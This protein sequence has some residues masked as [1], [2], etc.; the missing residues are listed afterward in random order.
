MTPDDTSSVPPTPC[1][2]SLGGVWQEAGRQECRAAHQ[3]WA[4]P[5]QLLPLLLL[6]AEVLAAVAV[7]AV[8]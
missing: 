3:T 6:V 8:Q 7:P 2:Q 4:R 5:F 1:L